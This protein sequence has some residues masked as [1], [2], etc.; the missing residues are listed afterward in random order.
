M[1]KFWLIL[2]VTLTLIFGLL[3][4]ASCNYNVVDLTYSFD[5]AY[6]ELP[7]G[8]LIEGEVSAWR[9]YEDGDQLQVTV[10]GNTYLVHSNNC[11]LVK[12][13]DQV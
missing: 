8:E 9:D 6:I 2:V 7:N 3:Y 4:L 11:V 13:G 10:N 1:R 12:Y 5:Y